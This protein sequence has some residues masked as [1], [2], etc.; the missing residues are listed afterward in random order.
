MDCVLS[1]PLD[2]RAYGLPARIRDTENRKCSLVEPPAPT[3]ST[4]VANGATVGMQRPDGSTTCGCMN[5][6]GDRPAYP[7][8]ASTGG[9]TSFS[10]G[11][12][13]D[14]RMESAGVKAGVKIKF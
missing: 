6:A 9:D 11:V 1:C 5:T 10:A 2:D 3:G 13:S 4:V 12:S 8:G 14:G 7:V